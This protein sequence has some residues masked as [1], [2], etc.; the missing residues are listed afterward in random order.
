MPSIIRSKQWNKVRNLLDWIEKQCWLTSP[1]IPLSRNL[2][3]IRAGLIG[4]HEENALHLA[5]SNEAPFDIIQQLCTLF[6]CLAFEVGHIHKRTALHS[7]VSCASPNIQIVDHLLSV[8]PLAASAKDSNNRSPLHEACRRIEFTADSEHCDLFVIGLRT[9]FKEE[10]TS[11]IGALCRVCP[12]SVN[13]EDNFG[14]S[15]IEYAIESELSENAI[16]HLWRGSSLNWKARE[17]TQEY[18]HTKKAAQY[19]VIR[20]LKFKDSKHFIHDSSQNVKHKNYRRMNI[21]LH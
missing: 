12:S 19:K 5:C 10:I 21:Q 9:I 18:L 13:E 8:N 17:N 14:M 2:L 20:D 7:A 4:E 15:P 11:I 1:S 16:K 3:C 6:P